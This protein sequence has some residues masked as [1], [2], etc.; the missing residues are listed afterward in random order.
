[1]K[2]DLE[3]EEVLIKKNLCS[4]QNFK[5][6]MTRLPQGTNELDICLYFKYNDLGDRPIARIVYKESYDKVFCTD[7]TRLDFGLK[8]SDSRYRYTK[9]HF[10][11]FAEDDLDVAKWK[12]IMKISEL[13]NETFDFRYGFKSSEHIKEV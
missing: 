2:K 8:I 9:Q 1:M 12:A 5:W 6:R 13:I 10:K 3:K 11:M 7:L 4:I